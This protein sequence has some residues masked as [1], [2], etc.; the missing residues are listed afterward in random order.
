MSEKL[1]ELIKSGDISSVR[2]FVEECPEI[3]QTSRLYWNAGFSGYILNCAAFFNK[4]DIIEFLVKEKNADI[5]RQ[6]DVN[7]SWTPLHHAQHTNA[8][9][10]ANKLLELG[11]D[12][13]LKDSSRQDTVSFCQS[14]EVKTANPRYAE[15]ERARKIAG[16]WKLT[17]PQEVIHDYE[18]PDT[19]YRLTDIFNFENRFWR[20]LVKD[21]FSSNV[22]QTLIFFDDIPDKTILYQAFEKL[23]KLGGTTD[24]SAIEHHPLYGKLLQKSPSL[25]G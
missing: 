6:K 5:N 15:E 4:P 13:T 8:Y 20:A 3:L 2:A 11:A 17:T 25:K 18:L 23:K 19:N 10:A 7:G 1:I 9:A 24:E 16:T 12:P 14:K 22:A 21:P